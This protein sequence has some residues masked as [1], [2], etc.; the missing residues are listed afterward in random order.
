MVITIADHGFVN[1]DSIQ[2]PD[3]TITLSCNYKGVTINQSYPRSKDPN[4]G[5]WLVISNVMTNTFQVDV[6]DGGLA[7]W[8]HTQFCICKWWCSSLFRTIC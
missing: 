6:G 4:S 5:K 7:A 1:G 3:G 2:I 8:N